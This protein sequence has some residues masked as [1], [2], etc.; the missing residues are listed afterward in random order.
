MMMRAL[1]LS[2]MAFASTGQAASNGL[3]RSSESSSRVWHAA[4]IGATG[5]ALAGGYAAG[6]AL[7]GDRPSAQPL[8]IA[9][10][11]F[12]GGLLGLTLALGVN[13]A[14]DDPGSLV[15]F[16]LRPVI[17]GLVG[18]IV[19]G[20]LAGFGSREPGTART[21]THVVVVSLLM[22]ETIVVEFARLGR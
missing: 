20:L 22:G 1:V 16:I 6:A 21:I 11:V 10:G 9:G 8:A 19:G 17:F 2:V 18:A 5:L 7:T 14:S 3:K 12:S 15:G 13:A 4:L